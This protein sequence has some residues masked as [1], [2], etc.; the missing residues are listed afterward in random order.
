VIRAAALL[1]LLTACQGPDHG[2]P[3]RN[4]R[5]GQF[6]DIPVPRDATYRAARAESFCYHTETFRCGRFLYDYPGDLGEARGYF[7]RTMVLPPYS[8]TLLGE[9][10]AKT[11][12]SL[13]FSKNDERCRVDLTR[14]RPAPDGTVILVR[15]NYPVDS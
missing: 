11:S 5:A 14:P 4:L 15:L 1:A 8:W 7:L 6:D 12:V 13:V 9:E 2:A 10:T 3:G